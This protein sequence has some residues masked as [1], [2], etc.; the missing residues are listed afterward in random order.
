VLQADLRIAR[1]GLD[2]DV[3][4]AVA[5]GEVVVVTGPS[6]A[7][8][9]TIVR[10]IAGLLRP[11]SGNVAC[12]DEMWF[13]A[14]SSDG[15]DG[16]RIDRRPR[17]RRIG[18]VVQEGALL[19]HLSAWRNVAF[20][21][22]DQSRDERRQ[23][24]FALLDRLGLA[25][26]VDARPSELSGGER[27]RVALARAL[28]RRP[29]AL[30][31]DEP[32]SALDLD[33]R[34]IA[35]G[36]VVA[37]AAEQ[38]IPV[39]IVSHDDEDA[40]RLGAR[41]LR[42][43][44]GRVVGAERARGERAAL[45]TVVATRR[46]APRPV[47]TKLVVAE[48]GD[49][50]G[51]VSGGCVEADVCRLADE[52]LRGA[53][54]R[55]QTYGIGDDDAFDVGLPC[56]GEIDVFVEPLPSND[57]DGLTAARIAAFAASGRRGVVL[58]V[59]EGPAVARKALVPLDGDDADPMAAVQGDREL[60]GLATLIARSAD[61]TRSTVLEHDGVRVLADVYGPPVRLVVV[62]AYDIAEQL[63]AL[64]RRLGWETA[65][66]DAR[67]RYATPARVPSAQQLVVAWPEEGLARVGLTA[68]TAVVVLTHD[69]KFDVPAL[70]AAARSP[71]FY[72][73][74]LGSRRNQE[75]RRPRLRDAGLS[76]IQIDRIAGPCGLDIGGD[77]PVETALSIVAEIVAR[78]R[79][80]DG[81]PLRDGR[82][83]IHDGDATP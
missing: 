74:A 82:G 24:A 75:R 36:E 55:L 73:G 44:H 40:V 49:V 37:A 66:V 14:P 13:A 35:I 63:C 42:L 56:G 78:E 34:R 26:R 71:A 60:P 18:L 51:S 70:A 12:G 50:T 45:A 3:R 27:Q 38:R 21:V 11:D 41:T 19:P 65:V 80:R 25:S 68:S 48:S 23:R 57:A 54:P 76:D 9:S 20:A 58:T 2:L 17:D 29:T 30:L 22:A 10:A 64:G 16:R 59:L 31:L 1:P 6:G 79:G 7:G 61:L 67:D 53:P 28:A 15:P 8:K 32:F 4:L 46:S 52:V 77:G 69:H 62:G 81:G 33:T 5:P 47:G 43:E 72:V 39:L 83:P